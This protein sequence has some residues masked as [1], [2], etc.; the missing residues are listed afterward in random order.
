MKHQLITF[1]S[2]FGLVCL[3]SANLPKSGSKKLFTD[4]YENVLGT[5]MEIKIAAVND[6]VAVKAEDA[7]LA[8]I[9]R[10]NKI[11][12]G[13][14]TRSE[15][16]QWMN[17][18]KQ[19]VK[20]SPELF[21]V[22]NLFD[23]WRVQTG[24]AL[25]ASAETV[26]R[27]WKA[28][29]KRNQLPSQPEIDAAVAVVKQSHWQLD[30]RNLTAQRLDD[31]ALMLN[32]FTKSYI[33][34]KACAAA[35]AQSGISAVVLNIGGDIV[36]RGDHTEQVNVTNPK[37]DAENDAP[38]ATLAINNKT[39]A[40][41]GNY[42]RGEMIQGQWYSH[43]VDPRTGKPAGKVISATVVA[44]NAVD[45]GA[46]ATSL[47]VLS[48]E[49]GKKLMETV[50]GAEYMLITADGQRTESKGWKALELS[51]TPPAVANTA[52]SDK[53]WDPKYELTI[54]LELAQ[55]EG[56]RVHRPYV[57]VWVTD[58]DKKPVRNIA[59]WYQKP[60]WLNEM[61]AWYAAYGDSFSGGS[62]SVSSTTSATR[63]PGQYT[64]KWDGKD[65]KG[66]LV[67]QGKYTINIEV[68]REHGTYQVY[69]QEM[70]FKK[71]EQVSLTPNT[72][73][74]SASLDYHKI[75]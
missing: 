61:R 52:I 43:I 30:G 59:L 53:T 39:I 58:A 56:M 70:D 7:A 64:L 68:A 67:K 62:N 4:N 33:M 63:G 9:D 22:L 57:A 5:S 50:P 6:Q 23:K 24:G 8:E 15:F 49:E 1:A 48:P 40:T 12:S 31:A 37:A 20:V 17:S 66:A 51:T 46:L 36:V 38:V 73:V 35:M 42:R 69:S 19:P 2:F 3:C 26:N 34:N 11:L 10:L 65:D 72:E 44:P 32:T 13:Y 71:A 75:K 55:I 14:D 25:D 29:A 27:V 47:N 60:R 28:A 45:A 16:S 54:N 18:T 41:S 74:A 21:Q